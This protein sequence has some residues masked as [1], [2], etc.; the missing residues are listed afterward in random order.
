[1][2]GYVELE[3]EVITFARRTLGV[4]L[5]VV[6]AR[7]PEELSIGAILLVQREDLVEDVFKVAEYLVH[8]GLLLRHCLGRVYAGGVAAKV[9]VGGFL[10]VS[11][12]FDI[13]RV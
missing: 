2:S 12:Q 8:R 11:T 6:H 9:A 13:T 3:P 1:M 5:D 10:D 7:H 4:F